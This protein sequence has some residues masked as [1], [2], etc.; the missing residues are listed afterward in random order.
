M[1]WQLATQRTAM[2]HTA[3]L[4]TAMQRTAMQRTASK[5]AGAHLTKSTVQLLHAPWCVGH[6]NSLQLSSL[7]S[8]ASKQMLHST[9][10]P[11]SSAGA[12]PTAGV[13]SKCLVSAEQLS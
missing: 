9:A 5:P 2:L 8:K 10:V 13:K 3:M 12:G 7:T 11:Q 6:G 4:H 1:S